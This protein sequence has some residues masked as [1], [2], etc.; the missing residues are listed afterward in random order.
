MSG[1]NTLGK[2]T[3]ERQIADLRKQVAQLRSIV[4]GQ[5][6]RSARIEDVSGGKVNS[7]TLL[8][9]D[10]VDGAVI[11]VIDSA[12][13]EI[14]QINENGLTVLD[15]DITI[16]NTNGDPTLDGLGLVSTNNFVT[17]AAVAI[18]LARF[19]ASTSFVAVAATTLTFTLARPAVVQ[20]LC[21]GNFAGT[22]LT[23]EFCSADVAL[24]VDGV[25]YPDTTNGFGRVFY[26]SD[27]L[28]G[29]VTNVSPTWSD[30]H[31]MTLGAGSHTVRLMYR[32]LAGSVNV[33]VS[34]TAL[35]YLLLGK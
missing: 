1:A 19:T 13:D 6:I 10:G 34:N 32:K 12:N 5:P 4:Q 14:I 23:G 9:K 8:I 33:E 27:S 30:S 3:I 35:R 2:E 29:D 11:S 20:F 26:I 16:N 31:I 7:G 25:L 24:Q 28:A 21:S 17:D 15:G 22:V 18:A